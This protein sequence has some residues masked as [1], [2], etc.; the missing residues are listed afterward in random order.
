MKNYITL[1]YDTDFDTYFTEYSLEQFYDGYF[2]KDAYSNYYEFVTCKVDCGVYEEITAELS[3][4]KN[5]YPFYFFSD[6]ESV[7]TVMELYREWLISRDWK[8]HETFADFLN[9]PQVDRNAVSFY[10]FDR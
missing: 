8:S 10:G 2:N 7:L 4:A 9:I 5:V 1:Y 6:D 3:S